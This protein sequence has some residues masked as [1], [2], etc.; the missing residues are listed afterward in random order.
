M[1]STLATLLFVLVYHTGIAG[2][3]MGNML[4]YALASGLGIYFAR[5]NYGHRVDMKRLKELV[6]FSAPLVPS[7]LGYFAMLYVNRFI[8]NHSLSVTEVGLYSIAYRLMFP[9]NL[10]MNSITSSLTPLIY[11]RYLSAETPAELAR[12]FRLLSAV[13]FALIL[14]LSLFSSEI[15]YIMATP[16]YYTAA[17]IIPPLAVSAVLSGM[18]LFSP[19]LFIANRTRTISLINISSGTLNIVLS[20]L[21]VKSMG[22]AGV[23]LATM[24]SLLVNFGVSM[25]FSQRYYYIPIDWSRVVAGALTVLSIGYVTSFIVKNDSHPGLEKALALFITTLLFIMFRLV[26]PDEIIQLL[27]RAR[28]LLGKGKANTK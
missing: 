1:S 8:I 23:A 10:I 15:L 21:L 6:A 19:G 5:H 16:E 14:A 4:G 11:N 28:A 17:K 27:N 22:L 18:N 13:S 2:I 20:I 26:K 9:V 7:S 3:L 12:I 25:L 24:F